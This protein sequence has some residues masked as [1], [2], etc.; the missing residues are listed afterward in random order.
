MLD[1]A[2]E[3]RNGG[4]QGQV[5]AI[6]YL[7]KNGQ[8]FI[9]TNF[10]GVQLK[11][12]KLRSAD[13]STSTFDF[14]D[15]TNANLDGCTINKASIRITP[16]EN[17]QYTSGELT[18]ST[19]I[20]ANGIKAD[21]SN[22]NLQGSYFYGCDF[23]GANFSNTN[24]ED[25]M[26]I[27]CNLTGATFDNATFLNAG[28][29]GCILDETSFEGARINNTDITASVAKNQQFTFSESQRDGL[30]MYL[31]MYESMGLTS[32]YFKSEFT[33]MQVSPDTKYGSK[34][35]DVVREYLGAANL[36]TGNCVLC[37]TE[38]W[39][40]NKRRE[41]RWD[42][43]MFTQK[44]VLA[45]N[46]RMA[47]IR[48]ILKRHTEEFVP[49]LSI[50][51]TYSEKEIYE[52]WNHKIK[53]H[54]SNTKK[55]YP[56]LNKEAIQTLLIKEKLLSRDQVNWKRSAENYIKNLINTIIEKSPWEQNRGQITG[57]GD[58]HLP[59][60]FNVNTI[61]NTWV[62]WYKNWANNHGKSSNQHF[63]RY[64]TL[65]VPNTKNPTFSFNNRFGSKPSR[66][67]NRDILEF[68]TERNLKI[69]D[70]TIELHNIWTQD[71]YF[72][73]NAF[74]V[75][76]GEEHSY[77]I[78]TS[79]L[80]TT[81]QQEVRHKFKLNKIELFTTTIGDKEVRRI[82][83]FIDPMTTEYQNKNGK[84]ITLK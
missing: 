4:N 25:T 51:E 37:K 20:F 75:Y 63:Y 70:V 9:S 23:R 49:R 73:R 60:A 84:W 34:Y 5:E 41:T 17:I 26:F 36:Y 21:F 78:A 32:L 69:D 72:H 83:L 1:R 15:L 40:K 28:L 46:D 19:I 39:N 62:D 57:P 29:S 8:D 65:D 43:K 13:L 61:D 16:L 54:F 33:L 71:D 14:S 64:H 56:K 38:Q 79:E 68:T 77:T 3:S 76:S 53:D 18:N 30:C 58:F 11:N 48:A 50:P 7:H 27:F 74:V 55:T 22:T 81:K 2:L 45:N 59:P 67:N 31:G 10:N 80:D 35:D 82:V 52:E 6:E 44:S 24:L 47:Y 42:Y 12:L 66:Y